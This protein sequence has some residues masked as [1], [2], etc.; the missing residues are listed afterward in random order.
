LVLEVLDRPLRPAVLLHYPDPIYQHHHTLLLEAATEKGSH[1]HQEDRGRGVLVVVYQDINPLLKKQAIH[2]QH[3]HHK[4]ILAVLVVVMVA[5]PVVVPV[6]P[7]A[8]DLVMVRVVMEVLDL[9]GHIV[10]QLMQVVEVVV[11]VKM[12]LVVLVLVVLVVGVVAAVV[13][14]M[15]E[16]KM[17]TLVQQT[18]EVAAAVELRHPRP[19]AVVVLE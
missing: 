14:V 18:Q 4:V 19:Q 11:M 10:V 2:L 1:R 8:P 9:R 16:T 15:V 6:A 5:A 7:A 12:I 13:V 3:H 17:P